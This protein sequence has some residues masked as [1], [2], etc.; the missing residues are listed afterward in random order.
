M[1]W[2]TRTDGNKIWFT[3]TQVGQIDNITTP[4]KHQL[5]A[6]SLLLSF[7]TS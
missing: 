7:C 1:I 4:A 6:T 3:Y 2:K 5:V